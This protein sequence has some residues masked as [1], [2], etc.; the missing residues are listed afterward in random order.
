MKGWSCFEYYVMLDFFGH[1]HG[2]RRYIHRLLSHYILIL[3]APSHI[4][5]QPKLYAARRP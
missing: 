2:N 5:P 3:D 1:H 4:P